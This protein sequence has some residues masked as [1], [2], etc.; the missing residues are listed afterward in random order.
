MAKVSNFLWVCGHVGGHTLA[1]QHGGQNYQGE[2]QST[3][4]PSALNISVSN[5]DS[6]KFLAKWHEI[7]MTAEMTLE[8]LLLFHSLKI[9]FAFN[10]A[11]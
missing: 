3:S 4:A 6:L 1:L 8:A 11:F 2:G 5:E 9:Q 10:V 7:E